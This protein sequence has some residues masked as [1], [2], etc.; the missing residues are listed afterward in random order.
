MS[1]RFTI[2]NTAGSLGDWLSLTPI[3]RA[4]AA[5]NPLVIAPDAPHTRLFAAVYQGMAEVQFTTGPIPNTPESADDVCFSQR[6]LNHYGVTDRNAIPSIDVTEDE[7]T[8]ARDFLKDYKNP[9]AFNH[10]TAAARLDKPFDDIC[11][12]RRLPTKLGVDIIGALKNAGHT[13][14]SFGTKTIQTNIYN[15]HDDFYDIMVTSLPDLSIRQLAACYKVIG[16]YVGTDSGD[17]HMMLAVGGECRLFIPPNAWHYQHNRILYFPYAWK[18]EPVREVYSVFP[19][20]PVKLDKHR[21][22]TI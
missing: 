11:N 19:K 14:L 2:T 8:W 1:E 6:I 9:V 15:N 12:Y 20:E 13:V 10:T 22:V 17:H 4:K 16:K 18:D 3:L 7:V 5:E 21:L